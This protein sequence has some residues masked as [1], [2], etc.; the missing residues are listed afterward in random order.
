VPAN[1]AIVGVSL[2][3]LALLFFLFE[4]TYGKAIMAACDNRVGAS[5]IGVRVPCPEYAVPA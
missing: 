2:G 3:L 5:L 1:L 4:R